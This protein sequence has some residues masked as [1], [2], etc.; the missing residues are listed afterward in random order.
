[1]EVPR[2]VLNKFTKKSST[3]MQYTTVVRIVIILKHQFES[4]VEV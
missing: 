1:M 2:F 4:K 3:F